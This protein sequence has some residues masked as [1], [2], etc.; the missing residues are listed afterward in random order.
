MGAEIKGGT[1]SNER[2]LNT[3]TEDLEMAEFVKKNTWI[4]P[5]VGFAL[6]IAVG[7]GMS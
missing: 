6:L 2:Y 7:I 4:V 3:G 5:A 1:G